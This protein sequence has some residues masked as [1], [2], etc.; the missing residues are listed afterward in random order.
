[1]DQNI[2]EG[3]IQMVISKSRHKDG[4][5]KVKIRPIL[6]RDKLT[7][8]AS[9]TVGAQVLHRNYER[10]ELIACIGEWMEERY[11]QLQWEGQSQDGLILVSK[12]GKSLEP[13]Y[14]RTKS[15]HY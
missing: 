15:C 10:G 6:L 11:M 8:Q 13:L 3:L 12:K 1:M 7:Y 5:S 9:E 2:N 4:P 14:R